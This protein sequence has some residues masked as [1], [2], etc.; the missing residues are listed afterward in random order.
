MESIIESCKKT[1]RIQNTYRSLDVS[2]LEGENHAVT[3]D[4]K[5]KERMIMRAMDRTCKNISA[6]IV[7][8]STKGE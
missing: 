5:E 8:S 6:G 3:F 4:M 7:L 1:R 2:V